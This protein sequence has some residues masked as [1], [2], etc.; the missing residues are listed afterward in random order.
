M[1]Y[2]PIDATR[3]IKRRA[4][5][6]GNVAFTEHAEDQMQERQINTSEV[7]RALR[8]GVV[9]IPGEVGEHGDY[10]YRIEAQMGKETLM[11]VVCIPK[12]DP[13]LLVI[14]AFRKSNRI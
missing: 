11:S 6:S 8:S 9:R 5:D 4:K 13:S 12:G 10:C 14:T 3:E 7:L 2:S 1:Y